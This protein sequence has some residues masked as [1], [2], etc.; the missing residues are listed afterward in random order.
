MQCTTNNLKYTNTKDIKKIAEKNFK[1]YISENIYPGRGIVIGKNNSNSW[2]LIYWI[3][4]RSANSRNRMFKYENEILRTDIID[5]SLFNDSKF[6]IYNAMR[7]INKNVIISNGIHTD[8]IFNGLKLG[9]SFF[10]SLK[11]EKHESD[12]P[13]FTPRIAG[14]LE[15]SKKTISIMKIS[16]SDFSIDKS[17]HHFYKYSTIKSGYGYCITTYMGEDTPLPSFKEDP[18]LVP[19]QGNASE[20]ANFYWNGLNAKNRVSIFTREILNSGIDNYKIINGCI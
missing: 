1:K 10:S 6:L 3:M 5:C 16:K 12:I 18:I 20:I 11:F 14:L 9:K 19:L 17:S 13:N 7:D 2:I 15:Q 4:G 8:T